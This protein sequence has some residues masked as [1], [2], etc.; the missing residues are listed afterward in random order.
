DLYTMKEE[1]GTLEGLT[2][3]ICGDVATSRVAKS[4]IAALKK[5]GC[6][7]ILSGPPELM[8]EKKEL[9][10]HVEI[11]TLDQAIPLCDVV[12]F[13]RVQHERHDLFELNIN[14]YN[15]EFGLN[16]KRIK[17][18]KP[19]AIIMHPGPFNRDVEIASHLVEHPQSRIFKQKENGVYTRMAILEWIIS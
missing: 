13:L 14:N 3:T 18:L 19:N 10:S 11:K 12:M 17:L 2:V 9:E 4:N 5:F 6:K 8:P 16:D 1:F 7:V 15:E